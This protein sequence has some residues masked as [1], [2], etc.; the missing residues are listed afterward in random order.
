MNTDTAKALIFVAALAL[1]IPLCPLAQAATQVG[2]VVSMGAGAHVQRDGKKLPM[3]VKSPVYVGDVLSTDA[4]GCMRVW[5][6]DDTTLSLGGGTVF[7]LE[8]YDGAGANLKGSVTGIAHVRTSN[9]AT[10]G[11]FLATPHATV[12]AR[13]AI[14]SVEAREST[15]TIYVENALEAVTVNGTSVPSGSKAVAAGARGANIASMAASDRQ[16]LG[17]ALACRH[18]RCR[19]GGVPLVADASLPRLPLLDIVTPQ[20]R[21]QF[22]PTPTPPAP[23]LPMQ[24]NIAGTLV[25]HRMGELFNGTGNFSFHVNLESGAISNATMNYPASTGFPSNF[26][27]ES[28]SGTVTGN[29]F[30]VSGFSGTMGWNNLAPTHNYVS[31]GM[32][33][34]VSRSGNTANVSGTYSLVFREGAHPPEPPQTGD[35]TGSGTLTK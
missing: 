4:T 28:G 18:R 35:F 5:F 7:S 1:A 33:G 22:D 20:A 13:K 31:G 30:S 21:V 6:N 34:N 10:Q 24:G 15:S 27:L 25:T 9:A 14:F 12:E 29:S 23:V 26:N 2:T 32:T 11:I 19:Q 8:G 3:P 17:V 16:M